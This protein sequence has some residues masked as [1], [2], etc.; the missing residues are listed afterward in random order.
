ML[1]GG[2]GEEGQAVSGEEEILN[3]ARTLL[4]TSPSPTMTSPMRDG[5]TCVIWSVWTSW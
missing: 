3:E 1:G 4:P 2:A 5:H